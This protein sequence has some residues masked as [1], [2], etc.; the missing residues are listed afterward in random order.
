MCI[1]LEKLGSLAEAIERAHVKSHSLLPYVASCQHVLRKKKDDLM[2][3][4]ILKQ[5]KQRTE[6]CGCFQK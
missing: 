2:L 3:T 5:M 1:A 6:L 4:T